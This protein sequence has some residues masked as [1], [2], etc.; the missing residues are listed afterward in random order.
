MSA[1]K[2]A[3]DVPID[4]KLQFVGNARFSLYVFTP[5]G[6]SGWTSEP[7]EEDGIYS[8][9]ATVTHKMKA[10]AAGQQATLSVNAYLNTTTGKGSVRVTMSVLQNGSTKGSDSHAGEVQGGALLRTVTLELQA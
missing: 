6:A 7:I 4:V 1:I 3:P 9:S 8:G 2:V 5:N 10:L